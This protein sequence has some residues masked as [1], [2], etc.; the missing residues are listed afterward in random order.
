MKKSLLL[1]LIVLLA[2]VLCVSCKTTVQ[3][4]DHVPAAVNMG[5]LRSLAVSSVVTQGTSN[6]VSAFVRNSGIGSSPYATTPTIFTSWSSDLPGKFSSYIQEQLL[7][8]L[9]STDFFSL[10]SPTKTD[11]LFSEGKML[12]QT[13]QRFLDAGIDAILSTR[14]SISN[15]DEYLYTEERTEYNSTT[16]TNAVVG[17]NYYI[18]TTAALNFEYNIVSVDQNN[19]ITS[20]NV[21]RN[22][23][24]TT[25]A[26][27]LLYPT[28]TSPARYSYQISSAP[29]LVTEIQS[30][31]KSVV[32]ELVDKLAPRWVYS[33]ETLM[34]N[35]SKI[36][37]MDAGYDYADSGNY[38][39]S[40]QVFLQE[41]NRSYDIPAGYNAA[42][43]L[44][45]C[46]DLEGAI[47]QMNQVVNVTGSPE[48]A[49]ELADM[50]QKLSQWQLAQN[51]VDGTVSDA[52][53]QE[54]EIR[55][56]FGN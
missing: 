31:A 25:L 37:S 54:F 39:A 42:I 24:E 28:A 2:V 19:L 23:D 16:R 33:T 14:A 4:K 46:G 30:I 17:L 55:N 12:G 5:N 35:K 32:K 7:S 41:W 27:T 48:A 11:N 49:G 6:Y 9:T 1:L 34:D 10:T 3:V 8:Q 29:S 26:A 15:F 50:K 18:K 52:T 36:K 13:R 47:A 38:N 40:Y 43:L 45:A 51:Q 20:G 21:S 22:I 44:Y 56:F 53:V